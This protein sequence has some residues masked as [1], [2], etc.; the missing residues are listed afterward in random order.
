MAKPTKR[1]GKWRIRWRDENGKRK[2]AQFSSYAEAE[3]ELKHQLAEVED[4]ER[5]RRRPTPGDHKFSELCDYWIKHRAVHKR[6]GDNDTNIIDRHL[7]P[8]FGH[9]DLRAIGVAQVDEFR[10]Q[11]GHLS[12]K[13][14]ANHLTLL[15]TMLRAAQDLG[16]LLIL[17]NIKKPR[18]RLFDRDFGYLK[19]TEEVG[20]FLAAAKEEGEGTYALFAT[21]VYTGMR[22]GEL[23]GL[24]WSNVNMA[25]DARRITVERSF[26]GPTKSGDVRRVPIVDALLP[27]LAHWQTLNAGSE[28][29]FPSRSGTMLQKAARAFKHVFKRVLHRAGFPSRG[30]GLGYIRFHDLRH[31]FASH[32]VANGADLYALQDVLGHHS[33]QMTQRYAHLAPGV[34]KKYYGVFGS[35]PEPQEPTSVPAAAATDPRTTRASDVIDLESRRQQRK[36]HSAAA[37]L[38]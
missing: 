10:L 29:V 21:A 9:L 27:I 32:W 6:S 16:W 24:R 14:L 15:M 28:I 33:T 37:K 36:Q 30:K 20:R 35:S 31:T 3:A 26:D 38:R 8:T 13:T 25:P 34:F 7:C 2:S 18:V 23:A 11:R 19:T 5:G 22:A 12:P 4:I 1:N 17:P